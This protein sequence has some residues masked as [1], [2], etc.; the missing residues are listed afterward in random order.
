MKISNFSGVWGKHVCISFDI[1]KKLVGKEC[2]IIVGSDDKKA[3][4]RNDRNG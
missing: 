2:H 3:N 1:F 4:S